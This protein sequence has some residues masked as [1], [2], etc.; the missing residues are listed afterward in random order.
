MKLNTRRMLCALIMFLMLL[1]AGSLHAQYERIQLRVYGLDCELCARGV[2]ASVKRLD[3]VK[4]VDV[5][6]KDGIVDVVLQPE[7]HFR[8]SSLRKRIHENGFRAMEAKITAVG[9]FDGSRF[10]V[11]GTGESYTVHVAESK[12]PPPVELTFEAR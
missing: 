12:S 2:A 11:T 8:M 10:E 9:K 5:R 3:G 6:L 1:A 7:S 4:S